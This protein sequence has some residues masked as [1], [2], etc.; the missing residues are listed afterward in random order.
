MLYSCFQINNI[1]RIIRFLFFVVSIIIVFT[2]TSS[3]LQITT[4]DSIWN[5]W[6]QEELVDGWHDLRGSIAYK[7]PDSMLWIFL[8]L[9]KVVKHFCSSVIFGNPDSIIKF[10]YVKLLWTLFSFFL[11]YGNFFCAVQF[12]LPRWIADAVLYHQR[13]I[14]HSTK[15]L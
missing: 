7:L 12:Y 9:F 4:F 14:R 3:N 13:T 1:Q 15:V 6:I 11:S 8:T 2:P 10:G 5:I